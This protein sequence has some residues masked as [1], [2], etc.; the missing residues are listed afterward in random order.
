MLDNIREDHQNKANERNLNSYYL[1][2]ISFRQLS[3]ANIIQFGFIVEHTET[4]FFHNPQTYSIVAFGSISI[5]FV[6]IKVMR[7]A[8]ALKGTVKPC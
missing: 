4:L 5:I 2:H 8:K 1:Y 3:V 7:K 6:D